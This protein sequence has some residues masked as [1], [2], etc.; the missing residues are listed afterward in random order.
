VDGGRWQLSTGGGTRPVWARN[1]RELFYL[2]A[3]SKLMAVSIQ[4]SDSTL[5]AGTPANVID[6][7]YYTGFNLGAYD[8]SL[9]SQRFVM[10]KEAEGTNQQAPSASSINVVINWAQELK[11]RVPTK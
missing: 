9:D 1:G 8:V 5:N 2:D 11:Q 3:N 10:I 4:S 7:A 6:K